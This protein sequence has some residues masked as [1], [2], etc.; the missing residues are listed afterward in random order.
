MSNHLI[1]GGEGTQEAAP[2]RVRAIGLLARKAER[3]PS[4]AF[5][6][7]RAWSPTKL[8]RRIEALTS[9]EPGRSGLVLL[10]SN[11]DAFAARALSARAAGRSLDLMY[12]IWHGDLTG[13]LL[14]GEVLEAADR[15]V[16]VR[17]LLDDLGV[18]GDDKAMLALDSHP[19]IQLR[20]FNPTRARSNP[21]RRWGEMI[22]RAWSINRRM[23]NKAWIADG[24]IAIVGGRNVGDEYYDASE[25]SNFR[26]LDLLAMGPVLRDS[27]RV[28]DTYWNSG[29]ALPIG[30]LAKGIRPRLRHLRSALKRLAGSDEARPYIERL[31]EHMSME[32]LLDQRHI[33][34][35]DRVELVADAPAKA[36]GRTGDNGPMRRLLPVIAG[37]TSRVEITSPYFIPGEEGVETLSALARRGVAVSVLTN[38]LAAT[39]VAA[40]HGGYAPYRLPLLGAGIRLFELKQDGR[41]PRLSLRGSSRASLHTKA[42]TVD[43][44]RGFIGSLNFDP[45]SR[46]LNTE[47]GLIFDHPE[48]VRRMRDLF[49]EET[50]PGMSYA[51]GLD[52]EGAIVWRSEDAAGSETRHRHEPRATLGRR[53]V[54]RA[55]G[56]LPLESQL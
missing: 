39:D 28:F 10:S 23:H 25:D 34:W 11:L 33:H 52:A 14:A 54:A 30:K 4:H 15:G 3:S 13:R 46:S 45:R 22:L 24:R 36:E 27:E 8:D 55:V 35:C 43:D 26:D 38:S 2:R 37:A 44:R 7:A 48:L 20:L 31:H 16:R 47:M 41:S 18:A 42:F 56:W 53:L 1:A 21:L 9:A 51:L 29:L 5:D 50:S 6:L 12:Y 40:V 32:N 17:L 19:N 49:E